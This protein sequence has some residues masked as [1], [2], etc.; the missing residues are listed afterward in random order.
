MTGDFVMTLKDVYGINVGGSNYKVASGAYVDL[1]VTDFTLV[2]NNN[3]DQRGAINKLIATNTNVD[4]G[5]STAVGSGSLTDSAKNWITNQWANYVLKSS[6]GATYTITS[7][8]ATVLTVTGTPTTPIAGDYQILAPFTFF[9]DRKEKVQF[10]GV[11]N[12]TI[13]LSISMDLN[14]PFSDA[15]VNTNTVKGLT[16]KLLWDFLMNPNTYFLKDYLGA[17]ASTGTPI[18]ILMNNKDIYQT[19]NNIYGPDGMPVKIT[20]VKI[21]RNNMT[22]DNAGIVDIKLSLVETRL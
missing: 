8:T 15:T 19:T 20:S 6:A 13:E 22:D 10:T 16:F 9:N 7:N 18:N 5:T 21:N 1:Q 14:H 3:M 17:T 11:S 12:P 4:D 2:Y